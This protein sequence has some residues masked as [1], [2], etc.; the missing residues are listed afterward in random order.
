MEN[1]NNPSINKP[2]LSSWQIPEGSPRTTQR[3]SSRTYSN[4][5]YEWAVY[6]SKGKSLQDYRPLFSKFRE[7]RSTNR[8]ANDPFSKSKVHQL[9]PAAKFKEAI[10]EARRL[11]HA[12]TSHSFTQVFRTG[13][14]DFLSALSFESFFYKNLVFYY[15]VWLNFYFQEYTY[16]H[17]VSYFPIF[18]WLAVNVFLLWPVHIDLYFIRFAFSIFFTLFVVFVYF[19]YKL[20]QAS[21]FELGV[22]ILHFLSFFLSAGFYYITGFAPFL[23]FIVFIV[24]FFGFYTFFYF[25][26]RR[27][28]A[29]KISPPLCLAAPN[30]EKI[31]CLPIFY[32]KYP[33][34]ALQSSTAPKSKN[35][36]HKFFTRFPFTSLHISAVAKHHRFVRGVLNHDFLASLSATNAAS[37][38][39]SRSGS[40]KQTQPISGSD[41]DAFF[42]FNVYDNY[43]QHL[44]N[45]FYGPEEH[46]VPL[47]ERNHEEDDYAR[48][49]ALGNMPLWVNNVTFFSSGF[50]QSALS[51]YSTHFGNQYD[52]FGTGIAPRPPLWQVALLNDPY[53]KLYIWLKNMAPIYNRPYLRSSFYSAA[54]NDQTFF[55]HLS[56]SQPGSLVVFPFLRFFFGTLYGC[57]EFLFDRVTFSRFLVIQPFPLDNSIS[58]IYSQ[59]FLISRVSGRF[60][61]NP[62]K[63][64]IRSL[65][66]FL[67]SFEK[68]IDNS[69]AFSSYLSS[70]HVV[71]FE[72]IHFLSAFLTNFSSFVNSK[73]RKQ[74]FTDPF[75]RVYSAT[76]I[77]VLERILFKLTCI[78]SLLYLYFFSF[79]HENL[80]C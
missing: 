19:Q 12:F 3:R 6:R 30:K 62:S 59:L 52:T 42:G 63:Q 77:R 48:S 51:L 75:F 69:I 16:L 56:V 41:F 50:R 39:A 25:I 55:P 49:L 31:L 10:N 37:F 74:I 1:K 27:I 66:K 15:F 71:R 7:Y 60:R 44:R 53:F 29:H 38:S 21:T 79:Y 28:V 5:N 78:R 76:L 72:L 8:G 64:L 45:S 61:F 32:Y 23:F 18:D 14:N 4:L 2:S 22:G 11:D 26:P 70:S 33:F 58:V 68:A 13:I 20:G 54:K 46:Y 67:L 9:T 73:T 34:T 80:V 65:L 40:F 57:I 36:A 24:F 47:S 35:G 17:L 43:E